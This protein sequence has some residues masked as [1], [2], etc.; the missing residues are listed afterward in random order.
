[1][2]RD[3]Y[4]TFSP[5]KPL[6]RYPENEESHAV[7]FRKLAIDII[8]PGL[9]HKNAERDTLCLYLILLLINASPYYYSGIS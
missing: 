4:V 3:M 9:L 7:Q 6:T 8:M 2:I 1:M 5:Q